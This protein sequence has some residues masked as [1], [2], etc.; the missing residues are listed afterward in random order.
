MKKVVFNNGS[1]NTHTHPSQGGNNAVIVTNPHQ[2]TTVVV[3]TPY[4][5][6]PYGFHYHPHNTPN[7]HIHDHSHQHQGSHY[8]SKP[9]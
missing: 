3:T 5:Q 2:P 6:N 7:V 8:Y 9:M 1:T 4:G